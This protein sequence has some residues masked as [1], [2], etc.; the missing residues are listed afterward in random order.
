[1]HGG[2]TTRLRVCVYGLET[3]RHD[4]HRARDYR[5]QQRWRRLAVKKVKRR[6]CD[7]ACEHLRGCRLG[8]W[9]R[10]SS[11]RRPHVE[12]I[13]LLCPQNIINAEPHGCS[14]ILGVSHD[15]TI[16]T[17]EGLR[18]CH[19]VERWPLDSEILEIVGLRL[20]AVARRRAVRRTNLLQTELQQS[21]SRV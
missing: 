20:P 11:L 1:L 17:A 19:K 13:R 2:S 15:L 8:W 14:D 10:G 12:D 16:L 18:Q 6:L 21:L 3:D 9:R 5:P 4:R 7:V